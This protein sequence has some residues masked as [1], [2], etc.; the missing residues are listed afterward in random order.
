MTKRKKKSFLGLLFLFALLIGVSIFSTDTKAA[1]VSLLKNSTL[2]STYDNSE[3][4]LILTGE[5]P[6]EISLLQSQYVAFKVDDQLKPLLANPQVASSFKIYYNV[7]TLLGNKF[8]TLT[9]LSVDANTGVVSARLPLNL[10]TIA[11]GRTAT[12]QLS[13]DIT[14]PA[15]S[16]GF[17]AVTADG[18]IN[19]PLL[20]ASGAVSTLDVVGPHLDYFFAE[21]STIGGD[22]GTYLDILGGVLGSVIDVSV[23]SIGFHEQATLE[24]HPNGPFAEFLFHTYL[25]EG[26]PIVIIVTEPNGTVYTEHIIFTN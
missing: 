26:T 18:L 14:I 13:G 8:G 10:L 12:Y 7:P 25:S 2:T 4:N 5:T 17:K 6:L 19:L 15:G 21:Y 9:N 3:L 20:G 23:P 11:A 22:R 16:Y 24:A 1:S